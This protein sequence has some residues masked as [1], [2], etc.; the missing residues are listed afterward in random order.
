MLIESENMVSAVDFQKHFERYNDLAREGK[1]PF[2]VTDN[3]KLVGVYISADEYEAMFG[4]AVRALLNER[5]KGPKVAHQSVKVHIARI[6]KNHSN[7]AT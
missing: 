1:G 5:A 7:E 4:T 3:A 6:L 2:A